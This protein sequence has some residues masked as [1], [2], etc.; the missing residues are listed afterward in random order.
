MRRK[1]RPRNYTQ[2]YV[3]GFAIQ[4]NAREMIESAQEALGIPART[5]R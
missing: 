2:L 5:C 3:V 1:K 4:P